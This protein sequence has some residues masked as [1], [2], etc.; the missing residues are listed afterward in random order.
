MGV[1]LAILA[2]TIGLSARAG[3]Y[4]RLWIIADSDGET[5]DRSPLMDACVR[6]FILVLLSLLGLF[7]LSTVPVSYP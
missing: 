5:A 3:L 6:A 1:L 4:G 2:V 7:V